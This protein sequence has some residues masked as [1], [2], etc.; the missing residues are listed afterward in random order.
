MTKKSITAT[1]LCWVVIASAGQQPARFAPAT[2]TQ[3]PQVLVPN[4]GLKISVDT[5]LVVETVIVKDKSGQPVPGLKKEDFT[6]AEDGKPQTISFFDYEEL[7]ETP[8]A[9]PPPAAAS[10]AKP[11]PA[12]AAI[13]PAAAAI[14]AA[15]PTDLKPLTANQ[16]SPEKSGDLRYKDRR[17]MVMFF[18]MTSM[19]IPDQVR[20]QTAAQKFLKTSMTP[21]D[22]MATATFLERHQSGPGLHRR[23]RPARERDQEPDH[24]HGRG[25]RRDHRRRQ[26]RR[27]RGR[28]HA[29]R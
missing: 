14:P 13:P 3:S 12:A 6:V 7:S 1:L 27:Q 26:H 11:A 18:D 19:P 28:L 5:Q 17:L 16:I 9:P 29:G 2:A 21:S 10:E 8:V 15:P 22:L 23:P 24:R 20:A 25:L 4:S